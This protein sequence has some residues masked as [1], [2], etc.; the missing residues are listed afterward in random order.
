MI[1]EFKE[2]ICADISV[3]ELKWV[4]EIFFPWGDKPC[5]QICLYYMIELVDDKQIPLEGSFIAK[6]TLEGQNFFIEFAHMT[7]TRCMKFTVVYLKMQCAFWLKLT[8]NL[9]ANAGFRK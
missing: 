5:H 8:A 9:L 4:G 3:K 1:R 6:E 2:E 7:R